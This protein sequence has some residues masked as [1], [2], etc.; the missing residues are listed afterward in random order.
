MGVEDITIMDTH[1]GATG[2]HAMFAPP[3]DFTGEADDYRQ[4]LRRQWNA[5]RGYQQKMVVTARLIRLGAK[6]RFIGP[7]AEVLESAIM[8]V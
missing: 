1:P 7:Y 2:A 6:A 4:W 3:G 8:R 5:D